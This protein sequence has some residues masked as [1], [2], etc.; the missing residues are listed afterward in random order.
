MSSSRK[1]PANGET[2]LAQ[3]VKPL[4]KKTSKPSTPLSAWSSSVTRHFA[5]I[6]KIMY[7][8]TTGSSGRKAGRLRINPVIT[9][10]I[11]MIMR[12]S[13]RSDTLPYH[14]SIA[15]MREMD[16]WETTEHNLRG[17]PFRPIGYS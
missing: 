7:I 2:A 12:S 17:Y 11:D 6:V 5:Q 14:D 9:I 3:I 15:F 10:L 4:S 8:H 1:H 16:G 13:A